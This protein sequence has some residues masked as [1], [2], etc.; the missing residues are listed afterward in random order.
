MIAI[1][2]L[3]I[4]A[5][6]LRRARTFSIAATLTLALG[7]GLSTAVFTVADALLLR[8]LPMRDQDRLVALWGET[9]DKSFTNYPLTIAQ[10][11]DFTRTTRTLQGVAYVA[12]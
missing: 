11:R 3:R 9:R 6:S 5:R 1:P 2:S 8:R 7:I 4:A 12:Y 10:T